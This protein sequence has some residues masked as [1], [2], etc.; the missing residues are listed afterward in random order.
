[1]KF[2]QNTRGANLTVNDEG[3]VAYKMSTKNRL[4]NSVLTSFVCEDKFYK[5]TTTQIVADCREVLKSD[6]QF[7]A[8]LALYARNE[9]NMR[10]VSHLLTAE[11]S[12]AVRGTKWV[13][14]V[15]CD[16]C[17]RPDDMVEIIAYYM[18]NFGRV[19]P[20][21]MQSG[22]ALAFNKFNAFSLAKYN[23]N[24]KRPS[25]IDVLRLTHP[26][27][28]D[29]QQ[30]ETFRQLRHDELPIPKTWET[31]L[32]AKGNKKEVWEA[33]IAENSIGYM[34][35]LRNLRNIIEAGVSN[36][37]MDMVIAKMKSAEEVKKSRVLPFRFLAAWNYLPSGAGSKIRDALEIGVRNSIAEMERIPGRT[38]VAIDISGSMDSKISEK[39]DMSCVNA[40]AMLGIMASHLCDDCIT[41]AFESR[42]Y[43]LN[44]SQISGILNTAAEIGTKGGTSMHL[45]FEY[46]M[47]DS[48]PYDRIIVLSDNEVNGN[49]TMIQKYASKYR[50]TKNNNLWVHA[51]DMQ[52]YGTQQFCG[53]KTNILAGWSEKVLQFILMR[54]RG[55]QSFVQAI[56]S[57]KIGE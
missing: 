6:P 24:N 31:E 33:L 32:S 50:Q 5:D 49:Q 42:L 8:K 55:V 22:I 15:V 29:A 51:V 12:N 3:H 39:S 13:K 17:V 20:K 47:Q 30:N 40:A 52:G 57:V 46:A 44:F 16:V 9:F 11:L 10:S 45:P 36:E 28:K 19:L 7:V 38:L 4:V 34:A 27:A 54:E 2:S 1:M 25:L 41:L 43:E 18:A 23:H 56:E 21:A 14:L 35:L 37:Y 48:R 26:T 53:D